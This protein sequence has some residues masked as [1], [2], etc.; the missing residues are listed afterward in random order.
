[1]FEITLALLLVACSTISW[2]FT[3]PD[4][5]YS[6]Y[7]ENS[8]QRPGLPNLLLRLLLLARLL[9]YTKNIAYQK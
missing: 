9:A 4:G 8:T 3:T 5:C 2:P 1:M 6:C 7:I